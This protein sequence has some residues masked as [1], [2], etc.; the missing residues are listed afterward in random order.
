VVR[1]DDVALERTGELLSDARSQLLVLCRRAGNGRR[2]GRRR[3]V[4]DMGGVAS[5]ADTADLPSA[6]RRIAFRVA[7]TALR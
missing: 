3:A 4:D 6:M 2:E 7:A 5:Y 1:A